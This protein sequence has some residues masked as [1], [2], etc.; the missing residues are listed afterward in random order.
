MKSYTQFFPK[1]LLLVAIIFYF[2]TNIV[3][4]GHVSRKRVEGRLLV[5]L[6]TDLA[7]LAGTSEHIRQCGNDMAAIRIAEPLHINLRLR[8]V[9]ART[10]VEVQMLVRILLR[11]LFFL[12]TV[13]LELHIVLDPRFILLK[14]S[15]S[16]ALERVADGDVGRLTEQTIVGRFALD[17]LVRVEVARTRRRFAGFI[18]LR[19]FLDSVI[20]LTDCD[21]RR[22]SEQTKTVAVDH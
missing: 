5:G 9:L 18:S 16:S 6:A 11:H 7:F 22:G 1:F 8:R 19:D 10:T 17:F 21:R 13:R 2:L 12:G 3:V 15:F 14:N 4:V 20:V